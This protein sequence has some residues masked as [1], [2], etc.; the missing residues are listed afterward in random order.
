MR[1][2]G[3]NADHTVRPD[4][5]WGLQTLLYV[6]VF[7][8]TA[9]V[10]YRWGLA[11]TEK[12]QPTPDFTAT[13]RVHLGGDLQT[14]ANAEKIQQQITSPKNIYRAVRQLGLPAKP[15]PDEDPLATAAR[16]T[17]EV[18]RTLRVTADATSLPDEL[19]VCI[20]YTNPSPRYSIQLAN[21]LAECYAEDCR[22][23]WKRLADQAYAAAREATDRAEREFLQA[24]TH[25]EEFC[26]RHFEPRQPAQ[27]ANTTGGPQPQTDDGR[28]TEDALQR[29]REIPAA[30]TPSALPVDNPEWI[31]LNEQLAA[32]KRRR[33][34]LL[35]DRTPLHPEVQDADVR[36]AAL[37][38]QLSA[39]PRKLA[40]RP[41][42]GALPS[43]TDGRSD[44]SAAAN[45]STDAQAPAP[46]ASQPPGQTAR[47]RA[48]AARVFQTLRQAANRATEAYLQASRRERQAWQEHQRGPQLQLDLA[49][50]TP[51]PPSS[52]PSRT[53][54][55][56]AASGVGLAV[57]AGVG[58]ISAGSALQPA[59]TT[60]EQVR[61]VLPVPIVGT[62]PETRPVSPPRNA[63]RRRTLFRWALILAGLVLIAG[64]VGLLLRAW[65]S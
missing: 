52:A 30:A 49:K 23:T 34:E 11:T 65:G 31:E 13:A 63:R 38:Q 44:D 27:P 28:P 62:I 32:L 51:A 21:T 29:D 41:F 1:M 4:S 25:L 20:A 37:R 42:G 53:A 43:P 40:S 56:L 16:I 17:G 6:A 54:L 26:Q 12:P 39:T 57:A 47:E 18:T 8:V 59:L 61:N 5:S 7:A 24:K 15:P 58:M 2:S 46:P 36:I 9:L 64:C 22:A 3:K 19:A 55:L 10:V 50:P 60:A 14:A 45:Q 35:V 33:A 48:E